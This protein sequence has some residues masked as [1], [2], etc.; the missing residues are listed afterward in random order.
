MK[1]LIASQN[2]HKIQEISSFLGKS[3]ELIS[4]K[5]LGISE[6]IP[7]TG[8]TLEENS[9][10]KA[11]FLAEKFQVPCLADDSGL[12]VEALNGEP[13]VFS[14]RY[15]GE[16]KVDQ[17]NIELLWKNLQDKSNKKARFVT[18][19]TF[20][21]QAQFYQF[22]GEVQGNIIMEKKGKNGF[23]YDPIF[24][25]EGYSQTFAEMSLEEKNQ[26]AHRAKALE[27]FKQFLLSLE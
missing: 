15:A 24:V 26:L 9:L 3:F 11:Q 7:E 13:G 12:E 20:F 10:L 1:I 2:Q 4:L 8:N 21:Y 17:K 6:D 19:L 14:A 27:K 18:I 22:E 25:P 23:G 5:D 16:P